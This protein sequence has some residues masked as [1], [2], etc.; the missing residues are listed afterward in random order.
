[1]AIPPG[2][3]EVLMNKQK[4]L[5]LASRIIIEA[6]LNKDESFNAIGRFLNKD[7]ITISKEVKNHICFEKKWSLRQNL[8][9]LM[10]GFSASVLCTITY[11]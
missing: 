5:T 1:M 11:N 4:H 6:M 10:T 9:W 2:R 8:H 3:K 7:C